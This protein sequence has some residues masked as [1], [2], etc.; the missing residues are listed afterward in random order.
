MWL[1]SGTSPSRKQPARK[2]SPPQAKKRPGQKGQPEEEGFSLTSSF[3]AIGITGAIF[4]VVVL[5]AVAVLIPKVVPRFQNP[6]AA[7]E[8]KVP[9][10]TVA[11]SS[12]AD[13]NGGAAQ[14][15]LALALS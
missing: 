6:G 5:G 11:K 14:H 1:H 3:A 13:N 4:G 10:P 7:Y 15:T 9:E 8:A 2:P 12:P